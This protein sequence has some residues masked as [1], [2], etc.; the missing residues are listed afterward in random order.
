MTVGAYKAIQ[1]APTVFVR[2]EQHPA[3]R[4]LAAAGVH[5]EALDDIYESSDT[6]A[7]V[8]ARIA[9]R[10]LEE[11]EKSDVVYAV[12]G[13]PLVGESAVQILLQEAGS[14]GQEI[15]MIGCESFI[16]ASLE[17]LSLSMD[18]GLKIIDALSMD[19]VAP[20]IDVG[21]LIYQVYDRA[22]ASE[23]KLKLMEYYP[24]EYEISVIFGGAPAGERVKTMPLHRLDRAPV[25]HLTT[26]YVPAADSHDRK[27]P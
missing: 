27:L 23:V 21:N 6:F 9:R 16:E 15:V 26:V 20:A 7:E 22:I 1:S 18:E 11:A 8:Y 24:D 2:T 4:D 19:R 10:I 14:A 13:H 17:A 3:V 12:P 25:D 5:F